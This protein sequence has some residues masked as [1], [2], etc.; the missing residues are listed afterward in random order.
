MPQVHMALKRN[1]PSFQFA[2]TWRTRLMRSPLSS[3]FYARASN[4]GGPG[5]AFIDNEGQARLFK[6]FR[7]SKLQFRNR[8]P[9]GVP[10]R[11]GGGT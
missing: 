9:V 1:W 4:I 6:T 2:G 5:F 8:Q 3:A 10:V 11:L 7:R